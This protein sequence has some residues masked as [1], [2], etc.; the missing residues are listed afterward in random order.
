MEDN[1]TYDDYMRT[2]RNCKD[3]RKCILCHGCRNYSENR[4]KCTKCSIVPTLICNHTEEEIVKGFELMY[5][6]KR[7]SIEV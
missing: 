6:D 2:P 7:F 1:K 3:Y 5:K 4:L